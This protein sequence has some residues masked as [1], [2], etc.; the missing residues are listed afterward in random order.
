MLVDHA[1]VSNSL[2]LLYNSTMLNSQIFAIIT[3][4]QKLA[5]KDTSVAKSEVWQWYSYF[6]NLDLAV[7][8]KSAL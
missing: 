6:K 7:V 5:I 4:K 1:G 2:Y 8:F 3:E